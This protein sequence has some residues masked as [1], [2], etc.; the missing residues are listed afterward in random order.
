M[1]R[2][3]SITLNKQGDIFF[4]SEESFSGVKLLIAKTSG[5]TVSL[6]PAIDFND[7]ER[8]ND[9]GGYAFGMDE[10]EG[11]HEN[12]A[13]QDDASFC[14][15]GY[16]A[17]RAK[18]T[19]AAVQRARAFYTERAPALH[20]AS[21]SKAKGW[22]EEAKECEIGSIDMHA[23]IDLHEE[24][25]LEHHRGAVAT[26]TVTNAVAAAGS[27]AARGSTALPSLSDSP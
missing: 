22:E 12:S 5:T 6:S 16:P 26:Q 7:V 1:N 4:M 18:P 27:E 20:R 14:A 15:Y 9:G 3:F 24:R 2:A 25:E 19:E 10:H 13:T 23:Y 8:E 21:R 17:L 11:V